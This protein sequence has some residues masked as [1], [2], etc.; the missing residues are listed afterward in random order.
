MNEREDF[1]QYFRPVFIEMV[2]RLETMTEAQVLGGLQEVRIAR[3]V[4]VEEFAQRI[5][6]TTQPGPRERPRVG[7][8]LGYTP[9]Q[10]AYLAS[11]Q[12]YFLAFLNSLKQLRSRAGARVRSGGTSP[13]D[14]LED[15]LNERLESLRKRPGSGF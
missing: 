14:S 15:A 9:E 13:F 8:A 2:E 7:M 1:L 12:T 6:E 5:E 4:W 10:L 3:K 11:T